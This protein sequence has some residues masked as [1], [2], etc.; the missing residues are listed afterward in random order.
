LCRLRF[1]HAKS[2]VRGETRI[3]VSLH[4]IFVT[5]DPSF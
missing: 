5:T 3:L 1:V 2:N 4:F